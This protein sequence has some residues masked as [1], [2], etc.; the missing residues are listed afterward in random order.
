MNALETRALTLRYGG[1][2]ALED[3]DLTVRPHTIH[4]LIGPNGAGKTSLLNVC[5]GATA[6]TS[7]TVTVGGRT[8]RARRPSDVARCGLARTFQ[9][10]QLFAEATVLENVLV[11][12]E[13]QNG[14]GPLASMLGTPRARRAGR[15]AREAA[16][17]AI[18]FVGLAGEREHV[19]GALPYG[20]QRLLEIARA[21]AT[22][23]AVLLLDEP[24]AGFNPQ[25]KQQLADLVRA[26]RDRGAAV[27]LV[28]HDMPLVM[29][30]ADRISVLDFGH[31]IAEGTP[32]EVANDPAV[33]DAYLG[34]D[35]TE[36]VA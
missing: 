32:A 11:G 20:K 16:L 36:G 28:E 7:G 2:T 23:P 35:A 13:A 4:A 12:A 30:V 26:I 24:G 14:V 25:E 22:D 29:G 18:E 27:L 5:S 8:R 10:L 34:A 9:N 33:V 3:V 21:L 31:L 1:V 17:E 15:A 19:A 6:A